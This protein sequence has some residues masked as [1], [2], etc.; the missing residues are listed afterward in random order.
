MKKLEIILDYVVLNKLLQKLDELKVEGYSVIKDVM[1]KGSQG[2]RDG[3]GLMAGFKNC[4]V[5]LITH[6]D[7]IDKIINGVNPLIKS[8]GGL[9]VVTNVEKFVSR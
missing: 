1:G 6:D 3:H 8:F 2:N 7:D 4:Y 5:M 9:C